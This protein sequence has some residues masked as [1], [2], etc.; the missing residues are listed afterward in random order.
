MN[1]SLIEQLN[2]E[3]QSAEENLSRLKAARAALGG[4]AVPAGGEKAPRSKTRSTAPLGA[5]KRKE[6]ASMLRKR[7]SQRKAA[8]LAGVSLSSVQRIRREQM[9]AK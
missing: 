8:K 5:D 6:I 1:T 3:I 2:A 9:A 7:I 4:E